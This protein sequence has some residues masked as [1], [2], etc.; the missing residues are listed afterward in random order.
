MNKELLREDMQVEVFSTRDVAKLQFQMN[1]FFKENPDLEIINLQYQHNVDHNG[2]E[3][4][5]ALLVY[6]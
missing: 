6:K 5:S 2:E 4:F 1:T 3:I